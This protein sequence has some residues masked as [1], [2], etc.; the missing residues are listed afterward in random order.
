MEAAIEQFRGNIARVRNLGS[1]ASILDSQT[2][3]ALDVSDILRAELAM[4][5]SALDLYAHEVVRLGMLDAYTGN[6]IRTQAFLKFQVS[7][8]SAMQRASD[9]KSIIWLDD[10]VRERHSRQSFQTPDNIAEAVRLM[11]SNAPLWNEVAG[12]IGM[13]RQSVTENLRLIVARRNQIV[14]EADADPSYPGALWPIDRQMTDEAV[15][16]MEQV[17]EAI[18]SVVVQDAE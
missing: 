5:V 14:H 2:T 3:E 17:V 11:I 18:H 8:E 15:G 7:L 9:P 12:T 1:L 6:R 4:A 13:D 16:F 10:Q